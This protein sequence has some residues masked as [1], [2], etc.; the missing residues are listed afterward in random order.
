MINDAESTLI[1]FINA[2][3]VFLSI[4]NEPLFDVF[5]APLALLKDTL[6]QKASIALGPGVHAMCHC[7]ADIVHTVLNS[8]VHPQSF[9]K[10]TSISNDN[11]RSLALNFRLSRFA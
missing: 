10:K 9:A 11:T 7:C 1:L 5:V 8:I 3:F 4:P 6:K 2:Y